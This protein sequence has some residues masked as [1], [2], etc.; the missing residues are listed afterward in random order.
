MK[1]QQVKDKMPDFFVKM[2]GRIDRRSP[3]DE[4]DPTSPVLRENWLAR[5]GRLR[6]PRGHEAV[7]TDLPAIPRWSGRYNT[8][9]SS[10]VSPKTFVYTEDGKIHVLDDQAGTSTEVKNLLNENA[11]PQHTLFQTGSQIEMFFVDGEN[12]YS[13]DGNNDNTF[14]KVDLTDSDGNAVS[15]VDL[16]EHKD[17][18]M[19]ISKRFLFVSKNLEPKVFDDANDSIQIVIG[20]GKGTN[21]AVHKIEDKLYIFNTEGI[22]ILDGDVI[23]ALAS[24][25][26]VRLIE[27]RNIIAGRTVFK[28]ERAIL[29]L[30]DDYELWSW[31]G[32]ATQMLT[33]E[34]KLKD[35]VNTNREMLDK[36]T[37]V[38]ENN[39]YQ[40]SFVQKGDVE[41]N[42]EVFWDAFENKIDIVKG[43]NVSC[44]MKTDPTVEAEYLEL[45][46]SN[47]NKIMRHGRG[48]DFGGVAIASRVRSRD[49]TPKKGWNVRFDA[50]YFQFMPTGNRDINILYLLDG[51]SSN[52]TGSGAD[53]TQNLRGETKTL[54][55]IEITNQAQAT[56]R[57]KPKI[58][59]SR[60]ES[61]AFEAIEATLGLKADWEGIGVDYTV[62]QKSKGTKIGA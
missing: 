50:F 49:L 46:Q 39:Y 33:F 18:L 43:R 20:S 26:E 27:E 12:M 5:D 28:V 62:K 29:F 59:Y 23:S 51:R 38:Y 7:I 3:Q 44:Y 2:T 42:V 61:V 37:A 34:L 36:A 17:R 52:P 32:N 60:G 11:Y 25:F 55:M 9:E 24:T 15:P 35:F 45:G 41:P 19:V 22:F 31:D 21:L 47:A 56:G 16:I 13:H 4:G 58:K 10:I 54:G 8:I 57:V 48:S 14:L 53:W 30:A 6:K 1:F 40:M